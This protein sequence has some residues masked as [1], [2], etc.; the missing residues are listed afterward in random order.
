M[1]FSK[2]TKFRY[3]NFSFVGLFREGYVGAGESKGTYRY[4]I[5]CIPIET[6]HQYFC[7]LL[8]LV[9]RDWR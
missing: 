6:V 9:H 7:S 1:P 3:I 2:W 5:S 8:P 4:E